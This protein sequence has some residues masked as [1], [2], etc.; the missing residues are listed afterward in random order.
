MIGNVWL[1]FYISG[2]KV[3]KFM[4]EG[5]LSGEFNLDDPKTRT[6]F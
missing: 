4:N 2:D 6:S 1:Q 3:Q 5:G